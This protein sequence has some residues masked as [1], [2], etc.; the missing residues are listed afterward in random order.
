MSVNI[1]LKLGICWD[2]ALEKFL[3]FMLPSEA[4]MLQV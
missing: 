1:D 2:K 3:Q 4:K